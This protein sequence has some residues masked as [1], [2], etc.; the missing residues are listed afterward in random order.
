MNGE[1]NIL[2]R[3][4]KQQQDKQRRYVKKKNILTIYKVNKYSYNT[5]TEEKGYN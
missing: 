4:T 3:K 1:K 2:I 5:Q